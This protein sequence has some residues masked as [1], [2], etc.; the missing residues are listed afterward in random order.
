[1]EAAINSVLSG[2]YGA[3]INISMGP[4][5]GRYSVSAA[6]TAPIQQYVDTQRQYLSS[7][8]RA[9]LNLAAAFLLVAADFKLR[10][11][12][13]LVQVC[14]LPEKACTGKVRRLLHC[15]AA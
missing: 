1:M 9:S 14:T 5:T 3:T 10:Q 8:V 2:S 13:L 15:T 4:L 12:A 6:L 7:V 11:L